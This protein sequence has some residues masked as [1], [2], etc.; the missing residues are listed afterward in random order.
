ML[1]AT[2]RAVHRQDKPCSIASRDSC[3]MAVA[4]EGTASDRSIWSITR[5]SSAP[6]ARMVARG[7]FVA[8]FVVAGQARHELLLRIE[9]GAVDLVPEFECRLA[10]QRGGEP[11]MMVHDHRAILLHHEGET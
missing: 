3:A 2:R 9:I 1:R 11:A 5:A 7:S 4:S 6:I 10:A 8:A